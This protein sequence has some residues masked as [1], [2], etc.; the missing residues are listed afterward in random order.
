[1]AK[2]MLEAHATNAIVRMLPWKDLSRA[3]EPSSVGAGLP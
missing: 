1:M 2:V 3:I